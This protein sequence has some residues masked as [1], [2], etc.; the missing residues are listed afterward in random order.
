MLYF[1]FE[2]EFLFFSFYS[3]DCLFHRLET[4]FILTSIFCFCFKCALNLFFLNILNALT[5]DM[6]IYRV[7][8]QNFD[9]FTPSFFNKT[10]YIIYILSTSIECLYFHVCVCVCF[11]LLPI[12]MWYFLGVFKLICVFVY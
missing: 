1:R 4:L 7:T 2:F 5:F 3:H 10:K 6:N 9:D 8:I 11:S 12:V